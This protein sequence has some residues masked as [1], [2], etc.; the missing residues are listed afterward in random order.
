[1]KMT[2]EE[3]A[4]INIGENLDA[5]MN[6]DPRGYGVCRI[7]YAGSRAYT[8]EPVAMH[9]AKQLVNTVK[10]G[11]VVFLIT[12]FVLRPHK[13]PEMDGI[14]STVLLAR[15]LVQAFDAKP[16]I[17][18]PELNKKAV[19]KMAPVVGLH[20]YEDLELV[21]ELPVSMGV[22]SFTTDQNKAE[23]QAEEIINRRL[24]SAVVAIEAPGANS[25]GEYHNSLGVN[26]TELE[27]K[28]DVLFQKLKEKGVLNI[29]IGDLGN[30]TGMGSIADHIQR[31]I[32]FTAEGQC[33]C[34]C[35]GGILAATKADH[36]ITATVSDWGCYAMMAALAYLKKRS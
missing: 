31:Y 8:G 25:K 11:D 21:E 26:V 13:V 9:A 19:I 35:H 10:A 20:C 28:T 16:V 4:E 17:I 36:I 1:M 34:Q 32:P 22:I 24:P 2:K 15:A 5:L 29:A 12:G 30:E 6:L 23:Q 27:A 14:V 33:Q 3:L 7:L 18:C